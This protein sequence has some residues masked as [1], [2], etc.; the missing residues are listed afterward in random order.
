MGGNF[1]GN[2]RVSGSIT[3]GVKDFKIDHPMDPTHKYLVHASIESPDMKNIYDGNTTTDGNGEATVTLPTYFE[4]LNRDFRYQL[5]VIGQ[6]AQAIV[7]KKVEDNHFTIKTDKPAVEVSWQVTGIRHDAHANAHPI[8]VEEAKLAEEVGTYTHPED[9]G[10][11]EE[12][13]LFWKK[14]PDVAQ[15]L[16]ADR[17]KFEAAG[18]PS[19]R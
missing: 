2:L 7:A 17:I 5:T 14:H 1:D 15:Q 12:K 4:A 3:A 6:F 10:Q 16:K 8:V 18:K 11:P 19:G 9:F 13:G